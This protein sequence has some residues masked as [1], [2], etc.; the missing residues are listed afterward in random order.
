M[1][2]PATVVKLLNSSCTSNTWKHYSSMIKLYILFCKNRNESPEDISIARTLVFLTELF[3]KGYSY[4]S[5]NTAR[6][7]LSTVFA[8]LCGISL[9]DNPLIAR[10]FKGIAKQRPPKPRYSSTWDV[11]LVLNLFNNWNDNDNLSLEHLSYKLVALLALSTAQRVQTLSLIKLSNVVKSAESVRIFIPDQLKTSR[12]GHVQPCL[13]FP[14]FN[15]NFK[16]CVSSCLRSYILRT[17]CLRDTD[18]LFIS[19]VKPHKAVT[20]QT[21]SRWLVNTLKLSG[22]DTVVFKGHSFRHSSTSKAF[23]CGVKIDSIFQSAGWSSGSSTFAKWYK[24]PVNNQF[25][26]VNNVLNV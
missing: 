2:L 22:I 13:T 10:L 14:V 3:E 21:L 15:E 4:S 20:S 9:G 1:G 26:F 24:R 18:S 12:P 7:A 11:N 16:L 19:F 23:S 8:P 17:S 5:I 6:S 25:E